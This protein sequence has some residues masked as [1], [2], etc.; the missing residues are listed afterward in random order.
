MKNDRGITIHI[1]KKYA[2]Y[3]NDHLNDWEILINKA[4]FY[5]WL[6]Q[7]AKLLLLTDNLIA[8]KIQNNFKELLTAK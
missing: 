7:K 3:H 8:L 2:S 1:L 6:R 4:G 5:V